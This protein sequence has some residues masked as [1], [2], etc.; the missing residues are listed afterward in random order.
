MNRKVRIHQSDEDGRSAPDQPFAALTSVV[1]GCI[2]ELEQESLLWVHF[3]HLA[4]RDHKARGVEVFGA[5]HVAAVASGRQRCRLHA[6]AEARERSGNTAGR[7]LLHAI[8]SARTELLEARGAR[9]AS[10]QAH[11]GASEAHGMW[12]C[13]SAGALDAPR[14]LRRCA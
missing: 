13:R 14:Q 4:G 1:E 3:P 2:T 7:A 6:L 9:H 11:G 8:A 10:G 5:V 12:R